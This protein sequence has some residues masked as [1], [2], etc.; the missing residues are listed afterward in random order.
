MLRA[1]WD[2]AVR[3]PTVAARDEGH[4]PLCRPGELAA[5]WRAGG[6]EAI[7]RPVTIDLAF[8]AFDD[9]WLP[10]L[11]GRDRRARRCR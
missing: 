6:L 11:G 3:R 2:E 7:E 4:M 8:N 5:L 9:Y 1:F 10:F